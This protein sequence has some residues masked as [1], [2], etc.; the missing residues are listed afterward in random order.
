LEFHIKINNEDE[1]IIKTA[2]TSYKKSKSYLERSNKIISGASTFSKL[3]HFGEG[4]TPFCLTHGSGPYVWDVDGNRYIDYVS[5][6]GYVILGYNYPDVNQ[7]IQ[8]QLDKGIAFSLPHTLEIE[9]A[10]MLCERLPSAEM[11]R[12]GKNGS[13]VTSAAVRLARHITSRDHIL[14]CG[15]HGWQ[16]WYAGQTSMNSGIPYCYAELSHKFTYNDIDSLN[17]LLDQLKGKVAAVIIEPVRFERPKQDFL[18]QVKDLAHKN[19]AILIFDE[20]KSCF[21]YHKQGAEGLYGVIPDLSCIGKT[22]ANGM[23]LSAVVGRREHMKRF[24]EVYYTLSSAG[25][26]LSLAATKATL[27]TFDKADVC[28]QMSRVGGLLMDGFHDLIQKY[29][30]GN[31]MHVIGFPC[32]HGFSF[33]ACED[34]KR[35]PTELIN[36][37]T[38]ETTKRGILSCEAHFMSFSHTEE[39]TAQTLKVYEEVLGLV[40][41]FV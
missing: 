41:E 27:E 34:S 7:A 20:I 10:E 39:T 38:Q 24:P 18:N 11:V 40:R 9:V 26:A 6:R 21:R 1:L 36:F 2:D 3:N 29:D 12:F 16:D 35:N 28:G 19:G 25:E 13:D 8:A 33:K 23:P 31:L 37:W 15:Y 17:K 22:I 30:L 4:K 5:S 32:F 14:F